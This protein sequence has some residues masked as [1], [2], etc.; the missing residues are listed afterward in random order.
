MVSQHVVH[1]NLSNRV[2]QRAEIH[3]F[4]MESGKSGTLAKLRPVLIAINSVIFAAFITLVILFFTLPQEVIILSC[5]SPENATY[6]KTP[7]EVHINLLLIIR[8]TC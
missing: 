3:H 5:A 7:T 6:D 8:L 4:T 2:L 1:E